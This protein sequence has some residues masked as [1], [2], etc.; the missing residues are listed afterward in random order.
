M[1]PAGIIAGMAAPRIVTLLPGATDTVCALGLAGA[2]VGRSHS[3]DDE[4]VSGA[5]VL[6]RAQLDTNLSSAE[7]DSAVK[8]LHRHALSVYEVDRRKLNDLKPDVIITQI[9]CDVCAVTEQQVRDALFQESGH[10]TEIVSMSASNLE[11]VLED[12]GRIAEAIGAAEAGR[13][14]L[15]RSSSRLERVRSQAG[16]SD[17]PSLFCMEWIDPLMSCGSWSPEIIELAGARPVLAVA[18]RHTPF[19]EWKDLAEADP[20]ILVVV[21]CGY[22]LDKT[23]GEMRGLPG[24]AEWDGLRAVAE[25]RVFVMDGA[26]LFNRPGPLLID[27]AEALGAII[28]A[29]TGSGDGLWLRWAG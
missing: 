11:G 12:I 16:Q 26:R 1:V 3:C 15:E 4:R 25:G 9:Q 20:D 13:E 19:V 28:S 2:V 18:G 22:G 24:R 6:T 21:P 7:I 5:A 17:Q 10:R 29:K 23:L 27:T 14:L 8:K